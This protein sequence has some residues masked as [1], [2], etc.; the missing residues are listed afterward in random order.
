MAK[1]SFDSVPPVTLM[2]CARYLESLTP[3]Q[4]AHP[5]KEELRT[6]RTG[7]PH[8]CLACGRTAKT[9]MIIKAAVDGSWRWL[10]LC[11]VDYQVCRSFLIGA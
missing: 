6:A 7:Q 5:D 8:I 4:E 2:N 9:A 1:R 10:D 11:L 3:E